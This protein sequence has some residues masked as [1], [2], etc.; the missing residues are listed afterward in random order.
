MEAETPDVV[1]ITE[2]WLSEEISNVELS[3]PN[4]HIFRL[5]RNRHGGGVIVYV[6]SSFSA[7]V[8]LAGPSDLQL[9]VISVSCRNISYCIGV[10]YRPPSSVTDIFDRLCFALSS[11]DS[12]YFFSFRTCR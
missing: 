4:Y 5:D 7:K 2:T 10:F 8:I 11:L 6:I 12:I 3:I 1:C 9:I